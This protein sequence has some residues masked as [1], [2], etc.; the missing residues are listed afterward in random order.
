MKTIK[1]SGADAFGSPIA[2]PL[3]ASD[4]IVHVVPE[5]ESHAITLFYTNRS[6]SASVELFGDF[7]E[8]TDTFDHRIALETTAEIIRD[9][10]LV[11]PTKIRLAATVAN[12]AFVTG[13]AKVLD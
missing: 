8:S 3:T 6:N 9:C 11:G 7:G 2:V 12:V 5:G 10:V 13:H 4:V 1:L